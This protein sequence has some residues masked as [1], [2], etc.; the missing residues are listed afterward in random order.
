MKTTGETGRVAYKFRLFGWHIT[1]SNAPVKFKPGVAPSRTANY[2]RIMHKR[3]VIAEGRCE[4]CGRELT[5]F[6]R[7]YHMLPEGDP[8]RHEVEN[9][10]YLCN[11]CYKAIVRHGAPVEIGNEPKEGEA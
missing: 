10:R 8:A 5:Q 6:A 7:L 3:R 9:I 11:S 2:D 4:R 1:I